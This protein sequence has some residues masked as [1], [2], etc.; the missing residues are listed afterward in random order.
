MALSCRDVFSAQSRSSSSVI[1][2][3]FAF[4]ALKLENAQKGRSRDRSFAQVRRPVFSS[5]F[6]FF[7]FKAQPSSAK[8]DKI[9]KG[10]SVYVAQVI[11]LCEFVNVLILR[12]M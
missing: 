11:D 12:N 8:K 1:F 6:F 5:P 4:K 2:V 3:F 7:F 9:S 10:C